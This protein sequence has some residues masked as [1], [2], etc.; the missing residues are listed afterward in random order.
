MDLGS[1]FFSEGQ[2][3]GSRCRG[4]DI[5]QVFII[6]GPSEY[7]LL[8]VLDGERKLPGNIDFILIG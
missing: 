8:F 3:D 4:I 6:F 5:K 1:A 7:L 2:R